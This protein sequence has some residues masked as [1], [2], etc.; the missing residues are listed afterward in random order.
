MAN[1]LLMH[2]GCNLA[3]GKLMQRLYSLLF[4]E[5]GL[6][7]QPLQE[8]YDCY[9]YLA[10]H[11]WMK[12]LWEK[13]SKFDMKLIVVDFNQSYPRKNNQFIMQVLIRLGYLDH[14]LRGLNWV[15]VS[16]QVLFMSD[17]HTASGNK[18]NS[19]T[20][21][22]C[23][24]GK[25]WLTLQWPDEQPTKSDFNLWRNTMLLICSSRSRAAT[26]GQFITNT[27]RIW[28][29]AWNKCASTLHRLNT[30]SV[31]EDAKQVQLL[32]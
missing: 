16:L 26:V 4:V 10:T 14:T 27:H 1:K 21:S 2:Y 24:R 6:S 3:T 5:V 29:W 11:L 23:P 12:M 8:S 13:L 31:T 22:C 20:L 17:I 19:N 15:R 32:P 9:G 30:D 18:I 25:A 28:R 7:F